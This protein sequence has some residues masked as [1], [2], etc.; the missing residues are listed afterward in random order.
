MKLF[1]NLKKLPQVE[2]L[3]VYAS[4]DNEWVTP[5]MILDLSD[6]KSEDLLQSIEILDASYKYDENVVPLILRL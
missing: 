2:Y 3:I 6:D 4:T 1:S 5:G